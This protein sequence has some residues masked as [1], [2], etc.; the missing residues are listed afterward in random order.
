MKTTL[1]KVTGLALLAA[2]FAFSGSLAYADTED[3]T[4]IQILTFD[5]VGNPGEIIAALDCDTGDGMGSCPVETLVAAD[6]ATTVADAF[7]PAVLEATAEATADAAEPTI[8]TVDA[9]IAEVDQTTVIIVT[10]D[11]DAAIEEPA[12][13]A[14]I[15]ATEPA[16]ED[17]TTSDA[18]LSQPNEE[19][20][21]ASTAI[22]VEVTQSSTV[23]VPGQPVEDEP[24]VTG[25]ITEPSS[26][27][28]VSMLD[29]KHGDEDF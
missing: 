27:T 29:D 10:G 8:R 12:Q 2:S 19:K 22:V 5:A 18:S 21:E 20:A 23:A 25:S 26:T 11:T 13:T 16:T 6:T 15:L 17:K 28:P 9:I 1:A 4:S 7:D 24:V 3:T 14:A